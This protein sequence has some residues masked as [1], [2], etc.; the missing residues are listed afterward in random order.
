MMLLCHHEVH[1]E[2]IELNSFNVDVCFRRLFLQN[3]KKTK[4]HI[5][6]DNNPS[7]DY[8]GPRW[9]R[10]IFSCHRPTPAKNAVTRMPAKF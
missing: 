6:G 10:Q 1:G 3:H 7:V 5:T 9:R 2:S 4:M 8:C